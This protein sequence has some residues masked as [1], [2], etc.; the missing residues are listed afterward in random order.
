MRFLAVLLSCA[1]SISL[2]G[3]GSVGAGGASKTMNAF[4]RIGRPLSIDA[5][6]A[7]AGT[8]STQ[9]TYYGRALVKNGSDLYGMTFRFTLNKQNDLSAY[10]SNFQVLRLVLLNGFMNAVPLISSAT[11]ISVPSG[12]NTAT[13]S[14]TLVDAAVRTAKFDLNFGAN[15]YLRNIASAGI[16]AADDFRTI[17]GGDDG[18]FFFIAQKATSLPR[19][20]TTDLAQPFTLIE[21]GVNASGSLNFRDLWSF[22]SLAGS[23]GTGYES[24]RMTT[25]EGSRQEGEFQ[26]VDSETGIFVLGFDEA[27]GDGTP[28]ASRG[29]EG[30]F[31]LSPDRQLILAYNL[32]NAAYFAGSR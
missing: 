30:T 7:G 1:L 2:A 22:S 9:Q 20:S 24:F 4:T 6:V 12:H 10:F 28:T 5:L 27:P 16:V 18:S 8:F 3:C 19:A 17:A 21:F 14:L 23:G 31:L 26:L 25:P 29:L 15:A 13:N 11:T 32:T